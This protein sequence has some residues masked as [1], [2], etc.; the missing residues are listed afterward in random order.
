MTQCAHPECTKEVKA[1][2]TPRPGPGYKYCEEHASITWHQWRYWQRMRAS[3]PVLT[4]PCAHPGCSKLIDGR[5]PNAIYCNEHKTNAASAERRKIRDALESD[6]PPRQIEEI[7]ED[8]IRM[9]TQMLADAE[10]RL[11]QG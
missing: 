5:R 4:R 8:F 3:R 1:R 10:R 7:R 11:R 9:F 2:T 6:S